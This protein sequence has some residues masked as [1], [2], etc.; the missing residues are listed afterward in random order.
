MPSSVVFVRLT[1]PVFSLFTKVTAAV[2][3]LVT[4][5]DCGLVLEQV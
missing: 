3:P 1:D 4:V 5:T 2:P